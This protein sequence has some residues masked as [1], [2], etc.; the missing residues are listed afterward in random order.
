MLISLG[1]WAERKGPRTVATAAGVA[2]GGGL[3]LTGIGTILH[4]LPLLYLGYGVLGGI[5]LF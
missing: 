3:A 4:E 2:W 1:P 5:G